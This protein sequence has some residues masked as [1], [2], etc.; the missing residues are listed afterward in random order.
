MAITPTALVRTGRF[1]PSSRYF[2]AQTSTLATSDGRQLAYLRRRF[3]PDP[4]KLQL[5]LE[6]HVTDQSERLD[7][8]AAEVLGDPL[9]FWR[10]CDA[11][12]AMRP[13]ELVHVGA[14]IRITLPEGVTGLSNV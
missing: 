2:G 14:V 11:N 8:L 9:Q 5:L 6:H 3:V 10:I 4:S 13:F 12:E 1:P 7:N